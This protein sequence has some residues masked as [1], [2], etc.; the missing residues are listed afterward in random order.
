MDAPRPPVSVGRA[1]PGAPYWITG[2]SEPAQRVDVGI[3]PYKN[4]KKL[5]FL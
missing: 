1:D 3:D 4:V 2:Y 5:T